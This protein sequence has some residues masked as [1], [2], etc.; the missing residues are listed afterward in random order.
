MTGSAELHNIQPRTGDEKLV[1]RL[2][3][4]HSENWPANLY[5]FARFSLSG[6]GSSGPREL[7]PQALT[8]PYVNL[9]IHT[10]PLVRR[11]SKQK[12]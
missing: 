11:S 9:S 3:E 8:D 5:R 2:R 6:E 4:L 12:S 7:P 10:A 1:A